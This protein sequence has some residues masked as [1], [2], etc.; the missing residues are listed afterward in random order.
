VALE[1]DRRQRPDRRDDPSPIGAAHADTGATAHSP[2]RCYAAY[3]G[4]AE[5]DEAERIAV[6]EE[7]GETR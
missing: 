2:G 1:C 6:A 5:A 7:L 4:Y 3:P